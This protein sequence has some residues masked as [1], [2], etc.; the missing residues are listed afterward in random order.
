MPLRVYL[1]SA[2]PRRRELLAQ[3]GI[4]FDVLEPDI[5]EDVRVGEL[6]RDYVRRLAEEKAWRVAAIARERGLA[7]RPVIGADTSV[8]LGDEVLGKPLDRAH[9]LAMLRRL[10]GCTHEVLTAVCVLPEHG[11]HAPEARVALSVSRVTFGGLDEDEIAQYWD[12]G[13]PRDKAGGYAIQGHAARFI[14]HLE[15]SYSGVMGL[16]LYELAQLLKDLG[17]NA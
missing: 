9:G 17:L 7:P 10:A 12:T 1:A 3:I 16:P 14:A 6:P 5:D 2:S 13:E 8:V 4:V 11:R 15:G